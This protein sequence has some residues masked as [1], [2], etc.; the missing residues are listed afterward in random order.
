[1]DSLSKRRKL[2][3]RNLPK[4]AQTPHHPLHAVL[5]AGLVNGTHSQ[6]PKKAGVRGSKPGGQG[7]LAW[8]LFAIMTRPQANCH[9]HF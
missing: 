6:T 4:N 2:K 1:V 9:T 7:N 8:T 5:G 3:A